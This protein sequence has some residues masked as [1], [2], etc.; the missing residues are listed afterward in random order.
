MGPAFSLMPP[1]SH[2]VRQTCDTI[3]AQ[4]A[5]PIFGKLQFYV[6][7]SSVIDPKL[8]R[9]PIRIAGRSLRLLITAEKW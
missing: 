5:N 9:H 8:K 1:T 3:V 6:I 4:A 7:I 2:Q